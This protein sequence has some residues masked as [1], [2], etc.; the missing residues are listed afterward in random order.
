MAGS[1][2]Y[3][4]SIHA[5]LSGF[6]TGCIPSN[7]ADATNDITFSVGRAFDGTRGYAAGA[8]TKRADAG[9]ALGTAQG[10]MASVAGTPITFSATTDYHWFLLLNP[11]TG[12]TDYGCD[13]SV[14]AANL[15]TTA[16]VMAAGFTVALRVTSLRA[17]GSA[18][19]P[20]FSAR[21]IGFGIVKYQLKT[22]AFEHTKNWSGADNTAQT[23]TL[24]LV[25]G[26]IQ[27]EAIIGAFFQDTTASASSAL[28]VTSFDQD[29]TAADNTAAGHLAT[30]SIVSN[31]GD[32][33]R[34]SCVIEITT[35]T[36]RTFRYRGVG[37]TADHEAAFCTMG[38]K[39]SRL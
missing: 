32:N 1:V 17:I 27:V 21:E 24:A 34:G 5:A 35:S 3:V 4:A 36:S 18:A 9:W 7:A 33:A 26:G 8:M 25:P 39:D 37:T 28:L 16:A 30:I 19:W 6:I 14:I 31:S 22:P 15:L 13:T 10:G 12:E 23:A 38:W 2:P 29:D 20:L 11:S